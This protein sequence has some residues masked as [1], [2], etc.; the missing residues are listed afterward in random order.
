MKNFYKSVFVT[1]L[2][3]GSITGFA[4]VP[5]YSSAPTAPA[6]IFLD[7]D[8]QT[9]YGTSWNV[10]GTIYAAPS[11][12]SNDQITEI[13]NRIAEDYRP[14]NINVTT[15]STKYWGAA[16]N[17]RMRAIFT[18]TNEW[19]GSGAGGVAYTGSFTWGNNTPCWIFTKLLGY[20]TKYLA[21][22]GAHEP[23]H[24]LG[25]RHQ[26][27][28]KAD[29][30][31]LE[32]NYNYGYGSGETSWAPIM[33]VGYY[34]NVTTWH[35]GPNTVGCNSIQNDIS[36]I[37]NATNGI[38][39][40]AD[41]Y[42]ETF[43]SANSASFANSKFTKTGAVTNP[44]EKDM[45]KFNLS[46]NKRFKLD[47][48]PTNVGAGDAGSNVDLQVSL[49]DGNKNLIKTFNPAEAVSVSVDTALNNGTY[50]LLV[51]GVGND[52]LTNYGSLGSYSLL[53]EEAPMS[54]L[55]LH[56]LSLKGKVEN[57]SQ[58]FSWVIVADETLVKQSLEVSTN[59]RDFTS[60][61]DVDVLERAY[62]YAAETAAVL[63]YR[64]NVTFD[65][66]RQYYSNII[67][68]R[69]TGTEGRPKLFSTLIKGNSLMVTSPGSYSYVVNDYNG[70][71]VAKGQITEG[72]SSINT[73]Y[74]SSGTYM[75]RFVRGED[76]YVEKFLKQ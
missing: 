36:V 23:G 12:L 59:G 19:Y 27:V 21:E 62:N 18:T 44:D 5:V 17:R 26:A 3:V 22:A 29:C 50:Y 4:Q 69:S 41:D 42:G 51:D 34:K 70:R 43:N 49:Y 28:W 9:V 30:S 54:V 64:L 38:T 74:L 13:Y 67:A 72:S 1:L 75:I 45:F 63:F 6:V 24:T 47:A 32:S 16:A 10:S 31:G 58:K 56:E 52:Y 68:L 7:F 48:I 73:N 46:S 60:L 39:F 25:L 40:T 14:F 57:G 35:N 11:G 37:T 8:G 20:N 55:P 33:G 2:L 66:G 71:I 15:D 76:Q 61:S 65:N 53:A